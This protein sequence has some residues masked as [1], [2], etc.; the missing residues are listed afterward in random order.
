MK[1]DL[2]TG[3]NRDILMLG[4]I[5][6]WFVLRSYAKRLGPKLRMR[7]G[8]QDKYMPAQVERTM[9]IGGCSS[10]YVCY[11]LCMYCD[12][13]DFIESY[14]LS[15]KSCDY[16]AIRR[17]IADR[18]FH[19]D[20]SFDASDVIDCGSGWDIVH[21]G[22]LLLALAFIVAGV[23]MVLF[24]QP[25][26]IWVCYSA[27]TFVAWDLALSASEVRIFGLVSAVFGLGLATLP[28]YAIKRRSKIP[29]ER[30]DTTGK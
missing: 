10:E 29:G 30:T 23:F 3:A 5:R 24:P 11:A 20:A 18:F 15:G 14:R 25:L 16:H 26:K 12:H 8:E 6:K 21:G 28:V 27:D 9:A 7:Y 13:D 4:I 2:I 17:E 22:I 19:G 1:S